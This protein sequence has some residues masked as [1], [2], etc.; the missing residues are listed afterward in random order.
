MIDQVRVAI[1]AWESSAQKDE[2]HF[3]NLRQALTGGISPHEA[4]K[5]ID[6]VFPLIFENFDDY[7][8]SEIIQI[9]ISLAIKSD[10]TQMPPML[11][12][13]WQDVVELSVLKGGY[14]SDRIGELSRHYRIPS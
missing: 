11:H 5:G 1:G 7:I 10:T 14:L 2:W 3:E 6:E 9:L 8:I 4:F 13:K 12:Q